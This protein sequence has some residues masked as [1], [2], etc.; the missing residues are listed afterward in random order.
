MLWGA[1][2]AA[3]VSVGASS[4]RASFPGSNGKIAITI[5]A[6]YGCGDCNDYFS[7]VILGREGANWLGAASFAYSPSGTRIAYEANDY[8]GLWVARHDGSKRRRLASSAT[9]PAW[10]PAGGVI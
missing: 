8:S 5:Q 9:A 10:S 6:S 3:L 2:G 7:T 1:I 4:A